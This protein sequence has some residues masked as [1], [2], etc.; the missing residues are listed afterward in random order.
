[1]TTKIKPLSIEQRMEALVKEVNDIKLERQ[2]KIRSL[3]AEIE[4]LEKENHELEGTIS[5]ILRDF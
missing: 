3:K 4:Q 2:A 5:C 1:M